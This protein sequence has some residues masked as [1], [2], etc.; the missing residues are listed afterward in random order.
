MG[1]LTGVKF[2]GNDLTGWNLAGQNITGGE[3]F[4]TWLVDADLSGANL[5]DANFARA[6]LSG[7]D[8]SGADG[9][10]ANIYTNSLSDAAT[11]NFIDSDGRVEGLVVAAGEAM[12]LWD[13]NGETPIPILV[14]EVMSV[15]SAAT[16]RAVFEDREWGSTVTFE[17]GVPVV[18]GGTLELLID[19]DV[20][21]ATLAGA[22]FQ[23][24]DW[25]GVLRFG[26]FD[27][28]LMEPGTTWDLSD[29]YTTG[30]VTLLSPVQDGDFDVDGDVDVADLML[31]Q[32]DHGVGDLAD[33]RDN[34][35][36]GPGAAPEGAAVGAVP[37]P[38]AFWLAVLGMLLSRR[39]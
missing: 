11:D 21:P 9:R 24:F 34:F 8:V 29:L 39:R 37:E 17:E 10:G 28:V 33:W 22:T 20:H 12:R 3:F 30:E 18:L 1:D 6:R 2:G 38:G 26:E 25:D 35:G 15:D 14:E 13:Y 23:V 19:D 4:G 27:S 36:F 16:L 32:R 7:V 31:W 5:G